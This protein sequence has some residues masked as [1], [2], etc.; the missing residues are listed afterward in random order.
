MY[1]QSNESEDLQR[2]FF[3]YFSFNIFLFY[4]FLIDS[5]Y[6]RSDLCAVKL[7]NLTRKEKEKK[8][9]ITLVRIKRNTRSKT[10]NA[11]NVTHRKRRKLKKRE[12]RGKILPNYNF[13][14]FFS[15]FALKKTTTIQQLW[16]IKWMSGTHMTRVCETQDGSYNLFSLSTPPL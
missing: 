16:S 1:F 2:Q 13:F 4:F 9:R 5:V 3:F 11:I 10:W 12:K 7:Q 15:G 8:E 6:I 14:Y